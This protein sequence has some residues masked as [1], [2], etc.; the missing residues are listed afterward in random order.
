M[1]DNNV[2]S[3]DALIM[4]IE[5][6]DYTGKTSLCNMLKNSLPNKLSRDVIFISDPPCHIDPWIDFK[7]F[8]E[9]GREIDKLSE[10]MLLLSARVDGLNRI[11]KPNL[12][13]SPIVIFDRYIDSWF[14]YQSIRLQSYF[15]SQEKTMRFLITINQIL[16]ENNVIIP[17]QKTVLLTVNA[18]NLRE[19]MRHR[20]VA[21]KY[22]QIGFLMDVQGRYLQLANIERKRYIAI[23]TSLK[24]LSQLHKKVEEIVLDL[25][26]S[27][28]RS[29]LNGT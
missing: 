25:A 1:K 26:P 24:S 9:M 19:R 22:E 23:D 21:S 14:A 27:E 6:I 10:A 12:S 4:S 8:F 17:P 15:G 20:G 5:G 18:E 7:E 28:A 11:V 2:R 13:R 16:E 29:G 3:S